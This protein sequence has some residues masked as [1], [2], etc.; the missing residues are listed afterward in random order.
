MGSA[1]LSH[2]FWCQLYM[3]AALWHYIKT[4]VQ[5]VI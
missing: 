5:N 4:W 3:V 2:S 1:G